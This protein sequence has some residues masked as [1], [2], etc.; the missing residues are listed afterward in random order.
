MINEKWTQLCFKVFW[1]T[2]RYK[3]LFL[4]TRGYFICLPFWAVAIRDCDT[5]VELHRLFDGGR[6]MDMGEQVNPHDTYE[7]RSGQ[8]SGFRV[9]RDK[10]K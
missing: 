3:R 5:G 2:F 4:N 7:H 8:S 1:C 6:V 9:R 10:R